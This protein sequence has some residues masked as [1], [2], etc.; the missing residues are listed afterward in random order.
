MEGLEY[1]AILVNREGDG[2]CGNR[3]AGLQKS[4][5]KRVNR[6]AHG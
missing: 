2:K 5:V 4:G 6:G 1:C 3:Q